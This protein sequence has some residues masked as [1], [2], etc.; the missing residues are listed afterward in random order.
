MIEIFRTLGGENYNGNKPH[1]AKLGKVVVYSDVTIN[2]KNDR[3]NMTLTEKYRKNRPTKHFGQK[4][5][6]LPFRPLEK[7]FVVAP[8]RLK[9]TKSTPHSI[10]AYEVRT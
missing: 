3:A 10:L 5:N 9:K 6:Q 4:E 7:N 1:P 2:G 8:S